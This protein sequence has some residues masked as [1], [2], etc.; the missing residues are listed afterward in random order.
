MVTCEFRETRNVF[1]SMVAN[2]ATY[3]LISVCECEQNK[4]YNSIPL[5]DRLI[6]DNPLVCFDCSYRK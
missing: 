2:N 1:K 3:K 6:I 5:Q 4:I